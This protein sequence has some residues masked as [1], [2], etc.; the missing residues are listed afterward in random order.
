L[1]AGIELR[2]ARTLVLGCLLE[3]II[4]CVIQRIELV[5][6]CVG[7]RLLCA[8]AAGIELRGAFDVPVVEFLVDRVEITL[9]VC[10]VA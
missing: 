5:V 7:R 10:R 6:S 8:L 3:A 1:A 4:E 2:R 9:H